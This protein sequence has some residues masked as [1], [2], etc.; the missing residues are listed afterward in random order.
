ML[1][2]ETDHTNLYFI[3]QRRRGHGKTRGLSSLFVGTLDSV[4]DTK[5]APFRILHVTPNSEVYYGIRSSDI[6][7]AFDV[8]MYNIIM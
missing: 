6:F 8:C 3:Q 2:R 4:F 7:I 5:P 1:C